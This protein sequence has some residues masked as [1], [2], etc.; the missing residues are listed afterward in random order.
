MY[1][2]ISR[3][4]DIIHITELGQCNTH[5]TVDNENGACNNPLKLSKVKK[6]FFY[7]E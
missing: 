6:I 3:S 7:Y 4:P 5:P 2:A 1:I